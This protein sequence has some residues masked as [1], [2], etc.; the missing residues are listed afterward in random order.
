MS[1]AVSRTAAN[2]SRHAARKPGDF[3]GSDIIPRLATRHT[4]DA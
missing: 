4:I 2:E 3:V 1:T